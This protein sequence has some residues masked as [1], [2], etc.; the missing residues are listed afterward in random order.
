M[1]HPTVSCFFVCLFQIRFTKPSNRKRKHK[2]CSRQSS[3]NLKLLESEEHIPTLKYCL[4]YWQFELIWERDSQLSSV[5]KELL[6]LSAK[7]V[8]DSPTARSRNTFFTDSLVA[9]GYHSQNA[10]RSDLAVLPEI[11]CRVRSDDDAGLTDSSHDL[12]AFGGKWH[13]L[14]SLKEKKNERRNL[15]KAGSRM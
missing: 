8:V 2:N 10:C 3:K 12:Q 11:R 5:C 13:L 15:L 7:L 1:S 6:Q 14:Q 9:S 4:S